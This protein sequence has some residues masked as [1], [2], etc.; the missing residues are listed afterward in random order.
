MAKGKYY[1]PEFKVQAVKMVV[2]S[3]PSRAVSS[4]ARELDV[5]ETTLGCWVTAYR[6]RMAGEPIPDNMP[7]SDRVRELVRRNRELEM[8]LAFLKKAAA[9]FAKE[10]R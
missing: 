7:D 6:K 4:V 1:T 10:H 3:R 5:N 8:E 9:Y 2:E